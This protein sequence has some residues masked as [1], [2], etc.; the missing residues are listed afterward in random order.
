MGLPPKH[1]PINIRLGRSQP[2][3]ARTPPG[4]ICSTV[5]YTPDHSLQRGYTLHAVSAGYSASQN[6]SHCPKNNL[7]LRIKTYSLSRLKQKQRYKS[8]FCADI[9]GP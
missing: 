1:R 5:Y 4:D 7:N 6:D 9:S 2:A 8:G 3:E